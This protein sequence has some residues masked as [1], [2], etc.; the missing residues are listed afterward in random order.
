MDDYDTDLEEDWF[1]L[2]FVRGS[3]GPRTRRRRQGRMLT[4]QGQVRRQVRAA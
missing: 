1:D 2:D 3:S 4:K